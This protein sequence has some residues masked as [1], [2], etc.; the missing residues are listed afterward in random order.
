[1]KQIFILAGFLFMLVDSR[2]DTVVAIESGV[3]VAGTVLAI[4]ASTNSSV[5]TY[6]ND[7][8]EEVN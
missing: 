4:R 1:M 2:G 6:F 5:C 8:S 3:A 7:V